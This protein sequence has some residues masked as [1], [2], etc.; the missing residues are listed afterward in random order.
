TYKDGLPNQDVWE[1][2]VDEQNRIWFFSKSK[3]QGF[4]E[5]DKVKTFL[6]PNNETQTV[7]HFLINNKMYIYNNILGKWYCFEDNKWKIFTKNQ[8]NKPKSYNF[9]NPISREILKLEESF[10]RF[11]DK[12]GNLLD[13]EKIDNKLFSLFFDNNLVFYRYGFVAEKFHYLLTSKGILFIDFK[14]QKTYYLSSEKL[15]NSDR[16]SPS[17]KIDFVNKV[18]QISDSGQLLVLNDDFEIKKRFKFLDFKDNLNIFRDKSGNFWFNNRSNLTLITAEQVNAKYLLTTNRIKKIAFINDE[19]FAGDDQTPLF[20]IDL[21]S[22]SFNSN[23]SIKSGTTYQIKSQDKILVTNNQVLEYVTNNWQEIK[24]NSPN[25]VKNYK[26]YI[27]FNQQHFFINFKGIIVADNMFNELYFIK[28]SGISNVI[29]YKNQ[30]YFGTDNGIFYYVKGELESLNNK[31]ND[32]PINSFLIYN[33]LLF[34][35]TSGNGVLV[36]D[37]NK[38]ISIQSTIGFVVEKMVITKNN[39]LWL[40]TSEGVLKLKMN[41]QS[42]SNS[43]I[44]NHFTTDDGLLINNTNDIEIKDSLLISAS[45]KGISMINFYNQNL[46]RAVKATFS[47]NND[48][49]IISPKERNF[50]SV[51]YTT[52]DFVRT[53]STSFYYRLLPLQPKWKKISNREINLNNLSPDNYV[54]ELKSITKNNAE[55]ISK[56]VIISSPNWHEF[57]WVKILFLLSTLLLVIFI[58]YLI[59][60]RIKRNIQHK[61]NIDTKLAG[62]EL[63][64]LRSQMNPHFV[65]NSLNA[66]LYYIQRNNIELSEKYLTKFSQL[67]RMFF[68]FSREQTI[69]LKDEIK[70]LEHYLFIE[71]LRFEEKIEEKIECDDDLLFENPQIPSMILQP[72]VENAVNHGIFHLLGNGFIVINFK[73][74]G[75]NLLQVTIADNGIGVERS[76]EINK[77][78]VQKKYKKSSYILQERIRLF[79]HSNEIITYE[80]FDI[81][82]FDFNKQGT[83]VKL[84]IKTNL[85]E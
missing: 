70:L 76:K 36:F 83:V 24:I 55:S 21:K 34:I 61:A 14:T 82:E 68:E 71:K 42:L 3:Y 18:I 85:N 47:V 84:T 26:D 10:F 15:F 11:H 31:E 72:L 56:L 8:V 65:H 17:T 48:T 44:V 40:A 41:H 4:I 1:L 2:E 80:I 9:F 77:K 59:I 75:D 28:K 33:N 50:A 46:Y 64:A 53:K 62:L 20:K 49:L 27:K 39:F 74:I 73:K 58:I 79:N 22:L 78:S 69:D 67:I 51:K 25:S 29:N 35:G 30:L 7:Y 60:K 32:S 52:T 38:F 43:Q 16:L 37:G 63:Q 13:Q 19:L 81:K 57:F 5:N 12:N 6:L 45:D 23:Y 66:I 54:L